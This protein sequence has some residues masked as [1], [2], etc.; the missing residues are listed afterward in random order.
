MADA[1]ERCGADGAYSAYFSAL[2]LCSWGA[3][4]LRN[5]LTRHGRECAPAGR[6][7]VSK[8]LFRYFYLTGILAYAVISRCSAEPNAPGSGLMAHQV[9]VVHL[10]RRFAECMLL[11]YSKDS[12]MS[13]VHLLVGLSYYPVV[14]AKL[15]RDKARLSRAELAAFLLLN[16]VQAVAHCV[17]FR[18]KRRLY[19]LHYIS[20]FL[21]YLVVQKE[22]LNLAWIASFSLISALNSTKRSQPRV[23]R[24]RQ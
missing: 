5:S 13:P 6:G 11:K 12:C 14:I 22:P 21:I 20:E 7:R 18:S 8:N 19:Y 4:F 17:I 10:A 24:L 2:V 9:F 3:Y 16:L 15:F 23:G 1:A